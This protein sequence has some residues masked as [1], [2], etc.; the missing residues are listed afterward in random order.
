M[1]YLFETVNLKVRKFCPEDAQRLYEIHQENPV[2]EWIP[3]ERYADI[4]EAEN[5]IN[6]YA[7]CVDHDRLPYVLAVESRL[8]G[9]LIGDTG[10]NEVEGK[11][12]E[13]EIG[14]VISEA[15]SGNGYAT[16]LVEAMTDLAFRKLGKSVLYGRVMRGNDASIRV[17]EKNGYS[18]FQEEIG[19]VDDPYGQGMMIYRKECRAEAEPDGQ[20]GEA[21][22]PAA[23]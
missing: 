23:E 2:R 15:F 16:E 7:D 13:V 8:T 12:D 11:P 3:N 19:A 22:Q 10:I 4:R 18:F 6:F 14:Y 17:L 9:E 1:E 20:D 21:E 5:A